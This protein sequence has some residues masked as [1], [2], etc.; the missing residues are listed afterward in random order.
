[1]TRKEKVSNEFSALAKKIQQ[2]VERLNM[3]VDQRLKADI[4]KANDRV[5]ELEEAISYAYDSLTGK[6]YS[7]DMDKIFAESV[8]ERLD[9]IRRIK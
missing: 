9:A 7:D 2:D 6:S 8:A 1:M 4:H 3:A 5:R